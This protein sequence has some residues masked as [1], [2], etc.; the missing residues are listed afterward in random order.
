V[1]STICPGCGLTLTSDQIGLD[2]RFQAS[3]ACRQLYDELSAYTLTLHDLDFTH[4]LV[5]DVYQAQHPGEP[6]KPIGI[7]FALAGLCLVVEHNYTGKEVQK[8]HM[9]M[10][11]KKRAWPEFALPTENAA[12]TVLD[13][14]Q[15][16][17]DR[18]RDMIEKWSTSVW[19]IWRSEHHK[20]RALIREHVAL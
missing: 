11:R 5:V 14:V 17:D 8:V 9:R 7:A 1:A 19:C 4:Q 12:T 16:P 3:Y 20:V 2:D 13:V 15:S 6:A 18:R 10:A